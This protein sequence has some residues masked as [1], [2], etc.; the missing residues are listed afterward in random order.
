MGCMNINGGSDATSNSTYR[1]RSVGQLPRLA[2]DVEHQIGGPLGGDGFDTE[3]LSRWALL[4]S[5]Q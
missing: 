4:G 2:D 3:F 1:V 5:N